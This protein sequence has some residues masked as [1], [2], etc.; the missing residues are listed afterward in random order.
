MSLVVYDYQAFSL[1]EFGG[2]SR[3]VCEIASRVGRTPGFDARIIAPVH[4]NKFL[5]NCDVAQTACYF[6]PMFKRSH[7]LYRAVNRALSPLLT[8]AASPAL[9]HRTYYTPQV[10]KTQAPVLITVHDMIHE[11]FSEQYMAKDRTSQEK[12]VS[13]AQADHILSNSQSTAN[14][15]IRLF[16]VPREKISI[17][18]LGYSDIFA[19]AAPD[20]EASPHQRPYILYVGQRAGYKNFEMVLRALSASPALLS[21]FDLMAFGGPA[22]TAVELDL[23]RALKLKPSQVFHLS[24][25]DAELARAYRHARV[26]VYPSKYEGFGVPPLEAMASGC[27]VVCADSSSLPEVVGQAARLFDPNE[28]DSLRSA[29]EDVGL[30]DDTNA[31]LVTRGRSRAQSF[32]WDRCAAET[33]AVYRRLLGRTDLSEFLAAGT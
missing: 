29:L 26:L 3:Y 14:D 22:L 15:L 9:I 28:L 31:G 11:L 12:R 10:N 2:V 8:R 32:S 25:S 6:P 18:H 16:G 13:L 21:S 24:S 5:P 23:M 20:S 27:A 1:Q 30:N 7:R 17:T 19:D 4:Y 33:V